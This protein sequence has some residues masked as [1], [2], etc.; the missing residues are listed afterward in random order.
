MCEGGRICGTL[1]YLYR[2]ARDTSLLH[3]SILIILLIPCSLVL[4]S[5]HVLHTLWYRLVCRNSV[6]LSFLKTELKSKLGYTHNFFLWAM[7]IHVHNK[8]HRPRPSHS[9][10]TDTLHVPYHAH[11]IVVVI[12]TRPRAP[13]M[14]KQKAETV[15]QQTARLEWETSEPLHTCPSLSVLSSLTF[16]YISFFCQSLH[17]NPFPH[18]ST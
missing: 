11:G 2:A 14:R 5:L 4:F 16:M 3:H 9:H 10:D 15:A 13:T 12:A 18:F 1:R 8:I 6:N 17:T 7:S